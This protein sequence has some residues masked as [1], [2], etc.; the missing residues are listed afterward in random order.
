MIKFPLFT[1]HFAQTLGRV[2]QHKVDFEKLSSIGGGGSQAQ[3]L[4][5]YVHE[6]H[7][8]KTLRF[9]IEHTQTPFRI[10][11]LFSFMHEV[12]SSVRKVAIT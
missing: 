7:Q 10:N 2:W 1:K 8:D 12:P 5:S 6:Y 9:V 3:L 11:G 4:G